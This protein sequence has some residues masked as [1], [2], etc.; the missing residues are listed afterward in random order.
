MWRR[1]WLEEYES[2]LAFERSIVVGDQVQGKLISRITNF[3]KDEQRSG[4]PKTFSLAERQQIVAMCCESPTDYGLEM[5]DWTHEMLAKTV[6]AE[7]ERRVVPLSNTEGRVLSC[8]AVPYTCT[9]R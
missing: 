3:L 1:R 9:E 5:T 6:V 7:G 2:L 8:V 4:A